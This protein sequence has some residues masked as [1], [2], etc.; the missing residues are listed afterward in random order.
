MGYLAI[1]G[2]PG[3]SG[4]VSKDEILWL[5]YSTQAYDTLPLGNVMPKV[6][7]L[8]AV[9][10]AL[11]TAFYMSRLMFMTFFGEYRGG[12]KDEH[13]H[14]H[15]DHGGHG[16]GHAHTPHESP[17]VLTL[18]L[19][20][21]AALSVF[22]GLLNW[23]HVL[24]GGAMME[25]FFE[26]VFELSA[27]LVSFE[28]GGAIEFVLMGITT[29]GVMASVAAAWTMY[30]SKPDLPAKFAAKMPIFY[31]GSLNKWFVDEIYEALLLTPI[32]TFSRQVLWAVVDAQVIDGAV[33]GAGKVAV[34][35]GT[36]H[37]KIGW[38]R[39]QVYAL[40]IA[41]GAALIVTAYAIGGH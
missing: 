40:S 29:A 13:A 36:L 26:P 8:I 15:D 28:E 41:I 27:K 22:G 3:F 35:A 14:G 16:H 25:H 21:L 18:P 38:G 19:M 31:T 37:G 33:N 24:G 2:V 39:V 30:V 32:V 4:F 5:T 17:L 6:L 20:I 34:L 9:C 23:P 11:M 1:I 10:T 12:H 7:W